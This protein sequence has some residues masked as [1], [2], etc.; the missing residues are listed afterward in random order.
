MTIQISKYIIQTS[1][2]ENSKCPNENSKCP[3]DLKAKMKVK[4]KHL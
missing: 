3:N 1:Q 2:N 4:R